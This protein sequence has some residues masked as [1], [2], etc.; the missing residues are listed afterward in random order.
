[1]QDHTA[2]SIKSLE[3]FKRA[4]I[5]EAQSLSARSLQLLRPTIRAAGSE[6]WAIWN[7]RHKT[8]PIDQLLR[9]DNPPTGSVVIKANW[10]DNPWFTAELEQE[11]RDCLTG[12]DA[13]NY[14]HIWEGGYVTAVSGAYYAKS[15]AQ[16]RAEGRISRVSRDPLMTIRAAWDI[17]GTGAK[18]DLV[19]IWIHQFVGREIRILDHYTAQG[20]ELSVHIAWLRDNGYG[21]ALCVLPHDGKTQDKVFAVSYESMLKQAGFNVRVVPNQGRGAAMMRVEAARRLFPSIWFNAATTQAGL[22]ALAAYAPKRDEIRGIDLGP[23]HNWASHD[24]DSFGLICTTYEEPGSK[25]PV[26][27]KKHR[28]GAVRGGGAW[29]G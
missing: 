5:E 21:N 16:A 18:A 3:G 27:V 25:K 17:G 22:E 29:M 10:R 7:P 26:E 1:M 9:G 19:S 12:P 20:Q 15:L 28:A 8:D 23:D 6:I 14:E 2:E 13:D 4:L 24:A 11:R